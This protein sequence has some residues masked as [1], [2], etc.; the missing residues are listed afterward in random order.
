MTFVTGTMK[1]IGEWGHEYVR[2]LETEIVEQWH[3][4]VKSHPQLQPLISLIVRFDCDHHAEIQACDLLMEIDLIH[5]LTFSSSTYERMCLYLLS[6]SKYVDV[7]DSMKIK[8]LVAS[9]YVEFCEWPRAFIL[10]M[11]MNDQRLVN[12]IFDE[13]KDRLVLNY[14]MWNECLGTR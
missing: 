11:Q 5:Q 13:C 12:K 14:Y 2:Q 7:V 9:Q 4:C 3:L 8:T 6:C 10:G 1:D